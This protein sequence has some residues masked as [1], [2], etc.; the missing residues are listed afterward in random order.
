MSVGQTAAPSRAEAAITERGADVYAAFLLPHL[1]SDMDVLDCGC[2]PATITIGLAAAVPHGRV[3]GVDREASGLR[4]A[5]RY[6]AAVG[7]DS[8]SYAAADGRQLPFRDATFDAVL[9]HS[10]LETVDDPA[11]I[12]GELRRVTKAGGVVAAA[13]V[14]CG[15]II[16]GGAQTSGPR[17]FYTIRQQLWRAA[18]IAD[19]EMGRRL[20]G[21]FVAA[22]FGRVEAFADYI[23]YG[24]QERVESFARERVEECRDAAL[25]DALRRHSIAP[26]GELFELAACW[27]RWAKDPGAFFAFA[28][29]RLLAWP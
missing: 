17:R 4:E 24:T 13:S 8:A 9:C 29:C 3:V 12:V 5:R 7:E 11:G 14:D 10:V 19:P 18:A 22:G 1:R 16:L 23:S 27:E 2:G 20:R 26:V 25:A 15:G 21:L 28:W 6:A